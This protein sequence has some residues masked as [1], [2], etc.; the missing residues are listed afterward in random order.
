VP[1]LWPAFLVPL[2]AAADWP[3][4]LGPARDGTSAETG[5]N[6]AWPKDGPPVLW[7]K[8]VGSG[9]SGVA[10]AGG[11]AY[12]FH[13]QDGNEVLAALDPATGAEK[14]AFRRPAKYRD[15]FG[16]DDGPR[17][18]P[19]VAGGAVYTLGANGD[20]RAIDAAAGTERWHRALQAEFRAGKGYFGFACSPLVAGDKVIVHVGGKGAGVVAFDAATGKTAWQATD[21]EAGYSSPVLA[22]LGGAKRVVSFTRRGLVGLDPATGAVAFA[23]PFRSRLD[24][25]VNAATPLVRDGDVFLTASYGTGAA[26]LRP[27]AGDVEEVWA[28][29]RTLSSQYATPVRVGDHLYGT[30]GRSDVGTAKLRCVAWATGEVKWTEDRFGCAGLIAADG[31]VLAITESGRLAGFAADPTRYAERGSVQLLD[32]K[33]RAVP[34]LA[35]GRLYVRGETTLVCVRLK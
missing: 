4:L 29:D 18:T 30:D 17:A 22:D 10:V 9:W 26:L 27:K 35:D 23:H 16:M 25:S 32:G 2:L 8:P 28:N 3:G 24:A 34:A 1:R 15:E 11:T 33:V 12:L 6:W 31:G 14:W 7:R 13:R 5:L 20:L 19:T 21:D